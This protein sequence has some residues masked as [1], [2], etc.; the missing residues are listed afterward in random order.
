MALRVIRTDLQVPVGNIFD[1]ITAGAMCLFAN[2][3]AWI[4]DALG[5]TFDEASEAAQPWEQALEPS[6]ICMS[7]RS[8]LVAVADCRKNWIVLWNSV[9][10]S[11]S[12]T[13]CP[14]A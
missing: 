5:R 7:V 6:R 3:E 13:G 12:S 9:R 10:R 1:P 11:S 2:G 8:A 14:I 4:V